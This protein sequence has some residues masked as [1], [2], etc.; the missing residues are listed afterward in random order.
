MADCILDLKWSIKYLQKTEDKSL[1]NAKPTY[2]IN[3]KENNIILYFVEN[4]TNL[5]SYLKRDIKVTRIMG[6]RV[7]SKCPV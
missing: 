6:Q 5:P 3:N 7:L 1:Y 4:E 2:D